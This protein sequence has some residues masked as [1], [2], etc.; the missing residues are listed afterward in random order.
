[1]TKIDGHQGHPAF[2]RGRAAI[3]LLGF[4][5]IAGILLVYEHSAHV[6]LGTWLL[7]GLL[8]ACP[9]LHLLM[10]GGHGHH[11]TGDSRVD[12]GGDRD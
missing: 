11:G 1:M 10:H 4:L 6:A 5:A 3:V 2:M 8:I 7:I 9:L 12:Q